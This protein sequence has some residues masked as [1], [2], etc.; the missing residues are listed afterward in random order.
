MMKFYK[1][2]R[3]FA[4]TILGGTVVSPV[5]AQNAGLSDAVE[6]QDIELFVSDDAAQ[7]SLI[8]AGAN[9][10]SEDARYRFSFLTT[11][12]RDN[13]FMLDVKIQARRLFSE[14]IN[15]QLGTRVYAGILSEENTDAVGLAPGFEVSYEYPTDRF[16]LYLSAGG[17][18]APDV[19]TFGDANR[20]FEYFGR[21]GLRVSD[22]LTGFVGF[23]FLRFDTDPD[24]TE[25]DDELHIGIRW[26]P[27]N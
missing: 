22:S 21:V 15:L 20:I 6:L 14:D 7:I 13:V 12:Q 11:E 25:V 9:T 3:A 16:P 17:Y 24:E 8:A 23:R 5:I 18:I 19:F 4:L 27:G 10:S 26:Q 1:L 2:C